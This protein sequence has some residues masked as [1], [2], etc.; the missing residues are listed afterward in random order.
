[1]QDICNVMVRQLQE[2]V[3]RTLPIDCLLR[4]IG[5]DMD[6]LR[7]TVEEY[8]GHLSKSLK[9]VVD[10]FQSRFGRTFWIFVKILWKSSVD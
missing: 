6:C 7:E 1:M 5:K 4:L 10:G 3:M 8:S 9:D 2:I